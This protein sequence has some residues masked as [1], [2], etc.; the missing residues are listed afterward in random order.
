MGSIDENHNSQT[1][2]NGQSGIPTNLEE[3]PDLYGWP[4]ENERGYRIRET[5]SGFDRPLRVVV[6]GCGA[7]GISFAKFAQDELK[8]VDFVLYEKNHD[9]G[10]T[11][12]ENRYPYV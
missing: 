12:L 7:S 10:G 9:V 5:P 11:W 1:I 4:R 6:M 3:L 2:G 8:N